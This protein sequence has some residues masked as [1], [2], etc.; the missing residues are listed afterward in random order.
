[1]SKKSFVVNRQGG[2][3]LPWLPHTAG[4]YYWSQIGVGSTGAVGDPDADTL[5]AQP[6]FVPD[7]ATYTA[8][9]IHQTT[10]TTGSA[11]LGIYNDGGGVPT[12][13]VLDA[14]TVTLTGTGAKEIV[15]SQALTRGWYWV[16]GV[17][18]VATGV[19]QAF[20]VAGSLNW[21]GA[22]DTTGQTTNYAYYSIAHAFAALPNP[23]GSGALGLASTGNVKIML[24]I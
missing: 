20:T 21:L 1:M 5:Y 6:F 17:W 14:G 12:T 19:Y 8:I 23:F 7:N 11:R 16:A 15:I 9:A 22:D 3:S 2:R 24:K 10:T 4:R 13:L 18:S